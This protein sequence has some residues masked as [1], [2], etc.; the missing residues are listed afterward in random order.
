[1]AKIDLIGSDSKILTHQKQPKRCP[2]SADEIPEDETPGK[3]SI[4]IEL[5]TNAREQEKLV[6]LN[7]NPSPL[8]VVDLHQIESHFRKEQTTFMICPII[9][10]ACMINEQKL[11]TLSSQ[12]SYSIANYGIESTQD[13]RKSS[14]DCNCM[15]KIVENAYN[16]NNNDNNNLLKEQGNQTGSDRTVNEERD[17]SCNHCSCLAEPKHERTTSNLRTD[18]DFVEVEHSCEQPE[19][20]KNVEK[21]ETK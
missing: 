19:I 2:F 9:G 8:S 13:K 4:P 17:G 12:G 18:N 11:K 16:N 5:V 21:N 3:G 1:M 7:N 15:P 10:K 14:V 6:C 20:D